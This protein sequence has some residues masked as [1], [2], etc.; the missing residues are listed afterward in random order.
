MVEN[1]DQNK[2]FSVEIATFAGGCFWCSDAA[3]R[4][5][6]GVV[7]VVAG[8][9]GGTKENP[10]YEEVSSGTTGHYEAIQVTFDPSKIT[11]ERLLE[12]FWK[13][14]DPTDAQG[15]FA[16]RGPQYLTAIFYNSEQ[17]RLIAER[18]KEALER[19]KKFNK[20]IVTKIIKA[21]TFYKAEDYHQNYSEKNPLVFRIY[22]EASG[23]NKYLEK[24]W[25]K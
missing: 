16:D 5:L 22:E 7:D 19:S 25:G 10:T 18:S 3:F 24:T 14:V 20:P 17:Q 15:Q 8:Y 6:P 2:N 11:Y 23:R 1:P 21:T 13:N 9:T 12:V 4:T